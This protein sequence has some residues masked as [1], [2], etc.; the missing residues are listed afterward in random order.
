GLATLAFSER[1]TGAHFYTPEL[2]AERHDG[3]LSIS[4]TK[5]FVTS[6]GHARLYPVLVNAPGGGLDIYVFTSDSSGVR[7]EGQWQGIG[8]SGNSSIAA[9]L[10]NVQVTEA[11]RLG[12]PGDGQE[13]VFNVVAP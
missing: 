6:G 10:D 3:S 1:G 9:V 4:G 5:S 8:M 13:L 7:F 12:Q 2:T 11:D